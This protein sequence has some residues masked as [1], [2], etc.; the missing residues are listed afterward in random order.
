MS[1]LLSFILY[2]SKL[3]RNHYPLLLMTTDETIPLSYC[4]GISFSTVCAFYDTEDSAD[5][6]DH[7]KTT[8]NTPIFVSSG[9]H[10]GLFKE[11]AESPLLF[12]KKTTWFV[13][14]EYLP[15]MSLRL[16]S[17]VYFYDQTRTGSYKIYESYAIKGGDP[18]TKLLF[19][20][21]PETSDFTTDVFEK[22]TILQRRCDLRGITLRNSF[23]INQP[24]LI[25]H[26]SDSSGRIFQTVGFFAD[27]LTQLEYRLNFSLK[28]TGSQD[29]WG[30]MLENGT[31]NGLMSQLI[32]KKIDITPN[33]GLNKERQ[34]FVDFTWSTYALKL[35]LIGGKPVKNRLDQW[36]YMNIFPVAAW[37]VLIS[38]IIVSAIFFSKANEGSLSQGFVMML[39]LL[40]QLG[41]ETPLKRK[42]SKIVLMTS[43]VA[44]YVVFAY[45]TCDLTA[46]MTSK[47]AP[48]NI[49]SFQDV[50]DQGYNVAVYEKAFYLP[51][52]KRAPEDSAMRMIYK[53]MVKDGKSI[54]KKFLTPLVM[55]KED[56]KT[57]AYRGCSPLDNLL[58]RNLVCLDIAE[59]T[60][61]YK[62][63]ALQ[64]NSEFLELID[65]HIIK[66][67]ECG[68][69]ARLKHKW[70]FLAN[71]NYEITEAS[72]LTIN[73]V[74]FTFV[75]LAFGI[76]IALGLL[77][78]EWFLMKCTKP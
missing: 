55:A 10:Q 50:I 54:T 14:L 3:I 20:W 28:D 64:K 21:L 2:I 44:Y 30:I 66:M 58:W 1:S 61:L 9:F 51:Y 48:L 65:H 18:I 39:R 17:R 7:L 74:M 11:L 15:T 60:N 26:N 57:L 35:T 29:G 36:A 68:W 46:K 5:L 41:Y 47:P 52:F 69:I 37:A 23:P 16:D 53:N 40:M 42:A 31:W 78:V 45:F 59:Y 38:C 25:K 62:T 4:S 71:E 22:R 49:N 33:M 70:M 32:S 73:N 13:P 72:E 67:Q 24:P 43:A 6:L 8:H 12:L 63:I 27:I 19:T 34:R 56:P 76:V 75:T 77:L